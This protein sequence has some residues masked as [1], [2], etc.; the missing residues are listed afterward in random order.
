MATRSFIAK[1]DTDANVYDA[2]YC[3]WDGYPAGVG[4]TLRDHYDTDLWA[5]MLVNIGDISS[6][7]DGFEDTE[8]ESYKKRG[9]TNVG[10]VVFKYFTQMVE[11]YRGMN[12]EYGYVWEDGKWNCY[13]LDPQEIN[14]YEMEDANV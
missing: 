4:V 10:P 2:I 14:L 8:R 7:R 3:H 5:K 1:Y 11:H 12:C 9:D 6:L 13:A